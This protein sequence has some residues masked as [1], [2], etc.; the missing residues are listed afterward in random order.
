[1]GGGDC[2]TSQR[3]GRRAMSGRSVGVLL[4]TPQA[5]EDLPPSTPKALQL[6]K[7]RLVAVVGGAHPGPDDGVSE[8]DLPLR[9]LAGRLPGSSRTLVH[10]AEV[11]VSRRALELTLHADYW[12]VRNLQ[13]LQW[14]QAQDA[15]LDVFV[16][17]DAAAAR[18][19]STGLLRI[20]GG[21]TFHVFP[22]EGVLLPY[23]HALLSM[24][25]IGGLRIVLGRVEWRP[26]H[27]HPV[28]YRPGTQPWMSAQGEEKWWLWLVALCADTLVLKHRGLATTSS[29][30]DDL[31]WAWYG[32][33]TGSRPRPTPS[34]TA[35]WLKTAAEFLDLPRSATGDHGS[36]RGVVD[37]A[38]R[39][40][41]VGL[42]TLCSTYPEIYRQRLHL[43]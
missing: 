3:A 28:R 14:T 21:Y 30:S 17:R 39:L 6:S 20:E 35:K 27:A 37:A 9:Q 16:P 36:K 34:T 22:A 4:F 24:N 32:G 23:T 8:P 41:V 13:S 19:A 5:P 1:M 2:V 43:P 26:G 12:A 25:L 31:A 42:E 11:H 7:D 29:V 10:D 33:P 15:R 18:P 38:I 40:R